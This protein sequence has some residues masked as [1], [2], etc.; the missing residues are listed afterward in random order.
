M[1]DPDSIQIVSRFNLPPRR[2]AW[3]SMLRE[4]AVNRG[5]MR[6]CDEA[7]LRPPPRGTAYARTIGPIRHGDLLESA[8]GRSRTAG[9]GGKLPLDA[10]VTYARRVVGYLS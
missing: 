9:L 3:Q 6:Y 2:S 7:I 1:L 8:L 4:Q 5:A 10:S